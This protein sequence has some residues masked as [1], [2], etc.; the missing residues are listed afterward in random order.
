MT[1]A[2]LARHERL[3]A[4]LASYNDFELTELMGAVQVVGVG[5]GGESG[6]LDVDGVP[7]FTKRIP[8]SDREI[9]NMGSTA[10]LFDL[11]MFCQYGMADRVSTRGASWPRTSSSP[12]PFWPA[13]RNRSRCSTTGG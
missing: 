10:N 12:T 5:V 1:S 4:L 8:L 9:A 13:R 3:S 6:V 7:V 11:P 2:R